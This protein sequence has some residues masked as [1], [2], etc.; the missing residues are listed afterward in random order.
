MPPP[1]HHLPAILKPGALTT[2]ADSHLVPAL[3]ADAGEPAAWRYIE[4]FTAN[5]RNPN[6]RR[7][8]ARACSQFFAWCEDRGLTLTTIRPYDVSLYVE[9]L[10]QT[11]SAPGVK[12]Q[13]GWSP[14]PVDGTAGSRPDHHK[15]HRGDSAFQ[16][17][18][19]DKI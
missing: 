12:Q 10:R 19:Q 2:P 15:D 5:I 8:Y 6:T 9:G 16:E 14:G 4:F 11:H 7:A 17:E 3:I 18:D 13:Q 1:D